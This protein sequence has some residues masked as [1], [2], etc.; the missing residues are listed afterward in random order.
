M[1]IIQK[2][3]KPSAESHRVRLIMSPAICKSLY[4]TSLRTFTVHQGATSNKYLGLDVRTF[5]TLDGSK[6]KCIN[7]NCR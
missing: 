6:L 5:K 1:D 3:C 4:C 2:L 7:S